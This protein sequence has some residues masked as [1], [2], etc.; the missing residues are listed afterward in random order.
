MIM[1]IIGY[2]FYTSLDEGG[3]LTNIGEV[4]SGCDLGIGYAVVRH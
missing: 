3:S 1:M 4:F 2:N